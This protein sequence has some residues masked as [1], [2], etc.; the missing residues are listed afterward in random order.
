MKRKDIWLDSSIGLLYAYMLE[1]YSQVRCLN[2]SDTVFQVVLYQGSQLV[3]ELFEVVLL[4][5]KAYSL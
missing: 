2:F 1:H 5:Q 3:L 4:D